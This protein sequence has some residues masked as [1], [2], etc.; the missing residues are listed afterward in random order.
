[1]S[2]KGTPAS[3]G[4]L[5]EAAEAAALGGAATSFVIVPQARPAVKGW[6]NGRA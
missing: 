4:S 5:T 1:M 3:G 2:E 6:L